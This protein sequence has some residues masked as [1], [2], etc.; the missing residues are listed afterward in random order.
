M[1][2]LLVAIVVVAGLV[3]ARAEAQSPSAGRLP[4]TTVAALG[5][6]PAPAPA[7]GGYRVAAR[8]GVG[9]P[10]ARPTAQ[11][12]KPFSGVTSSPTVSPYLNLF[13]DESETGAPNYF[14]FVRPMQ[15]QFEANR[16]QINQ[17]QQLQRQV[18]QTAYPAPATGV[19]GGARYGYTGR[20]FGGVQR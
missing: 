11:G 3:A 13:R 2:R 17:L 10:T 5:A 4:R 20:Y 1:I 12:Y 7:Y 18:Q 8:T 15:D 9:A 14:T 16:Q 6:A 19:S